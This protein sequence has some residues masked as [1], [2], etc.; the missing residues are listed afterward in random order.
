[1]TAPL[2]GLKLLVIEDNYLI[3]SL[4]KQILISAGCIVS[5]PIPELVQAEDA[6]RHG[7]YDAV[8]LDINLHGVH[9]YP[10]S[11]ILSDRSIPHLFLSGYS[12]QNIP[13]K[14]SGRPKLG[15]PF[16]REQLL[17]A[18]SRLVS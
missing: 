2:I 6:A 18:V 7:D 9:V 13:I 10:V 5:E 15:K 12:H 3:A 4:L 8:V 14:Y 11:D 1:M 16:R 17:D